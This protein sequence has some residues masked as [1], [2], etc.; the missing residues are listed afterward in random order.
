MGAPETFDPLADLRGAGLSVTLD[1]G[2]FI[3]RPAS[4]LTDDQRAAIQQNRVGIVAALEAECA[5]LTALVRRVCAAYACPPEEVADALRV[6]LADP[7]AALEC[8]R[9]M[10]DQLDAEQADTQPD[11]PDHDDNRI[12]CRQCARRNPAGLCE[13]A[14]D[15]RVVGVPRRYSPAP[16]QRRRCEGFAP[17]YGIADRRTGAERWPWLADTL[18]RQREDER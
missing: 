9:R 13:A 5:E 18:K 1:T 11:A 14:H 15:G 10:A 3:V 4:E 6:A 7:V 12:T 17:L 16:D 2:R 8:F